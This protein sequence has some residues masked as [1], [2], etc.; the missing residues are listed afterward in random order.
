MIFFIS[1]RQPEP[2]ISPLAADDAMKTLLSL[3]FSHYADSDYF[4]T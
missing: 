4:Q 2:A 1:L 3:A